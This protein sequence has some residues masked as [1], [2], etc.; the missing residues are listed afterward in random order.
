[1][2]ITQNNA[3][4]NRPFGL[5]HSDRKTLIECH[6]IQRQSITVS[7]GERERLQTLTKVADLI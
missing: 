3:P 5:G 2:V 7:K 6:S 4:A 1:M